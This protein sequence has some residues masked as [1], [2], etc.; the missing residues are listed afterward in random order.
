MVNVVMGGEEVGD[1]DPW[2][3]ASICQ[4]MKIPNVMTAPQGFLFACPSCLHWHQ[5]RKHQV[6]EMNQSRQIYSHHELPEQ[7]EQG[8]GFMPQVANTHQV[9]ESISEVSFSSDLVSLLHNLLP[10]LQ[11]NVT[12]PFFPSGKVDHGL[13]NEILKLRIQFVAEPGNQPKR[14]RISLCARSSFRKKKKEL[15]QL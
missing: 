13:F 2:C 5:L 11:Q 15:T 3:F 8:L 4:R 7:G 1:F 9:D 14:C 10:E 6:K 12:F